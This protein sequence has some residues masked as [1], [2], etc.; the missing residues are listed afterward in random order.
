VEETE[1]LI[2]ALALVLDTTIAVL[3]ELAAQEL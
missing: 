2:L 1:L 3:L